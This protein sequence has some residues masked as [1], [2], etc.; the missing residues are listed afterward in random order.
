MGLLGKLFGGAKRNEKLAAWGKSV[1]ITN[2][3][4]EVMWEL[5]IAG[6][7][8]KPPAIDP[9]C[10]LNSEDK[11]YILRIC[12]ADFRPIEFGN[13]N[14]LRLGSFRY[15]KGLGFN[16]EQSAVIVGMMFNMVGR[17]DL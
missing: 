9:L 14:T 7:I 17:R 2:L 3:Q 15:F 8:R 13:A 10:K 6:K 1:P 16:P 11:E 5:W 12:G 4:Q